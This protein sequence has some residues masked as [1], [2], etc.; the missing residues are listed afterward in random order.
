MDTLIGPQDCSDFNP[1]E[2]GKDFLS[3]Y[4]DV[5]RGS[6]RMQ[7]WNCERPQEILRVFNKLT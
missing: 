4:I 7:S 3:R 6:V 1:V 5:A 2:I